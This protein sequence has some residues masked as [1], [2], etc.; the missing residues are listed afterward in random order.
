MTLIPNLLIVAGTGTKTGKTTM[1]CRIIGKFRKKEIIAVKISPHFHEKTEGLEEI[2]T[3]EGFAI[4]S[5]TDPG[6]GKDTSRMLRSGASKVYLATVWDSDLA[7]VFKRIISKIPRNIPVVCES[8][9][10]RKYYEPG[11]FIVM[12]SDTSNKRQDLKHLLDLP[13]LSFKL[14]ELDLVEDL[15]VNF[16]NGKWISGIQ[17]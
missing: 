17:F 9:A 1:A 15:P 11:L 6:S 14:E 4:Y 10:L 7:E 3:G 2:E 8:P 12:T 13:H 16:I 5:E